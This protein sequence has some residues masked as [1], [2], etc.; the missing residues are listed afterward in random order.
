MNKQAIIT[1][2]LLLS[3]VSGWAQKVWT[4]PGYRNEPHGFQFDVNEVE[5]R[6]EETDRFFW[7]ECETHVTYKRNNP[8]RQGR[9]E[10][11]GY[12]SIKLCRNSVAVMIGNIEYSS[13]P[14]LSLVI[15]TSQPPARAH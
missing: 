3:T 2:L 10:G 4:N 15:I 6:P 9:G 8:S 5:F 11:Y 12:S 7:N 14:F 13:K 1:L